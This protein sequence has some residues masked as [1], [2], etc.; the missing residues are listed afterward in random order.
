MGGIQCQFYH[1]VGLHTDYPLAL[2]CSKYY[3]WYLSKYYIDGWLASLLAG[4]CCNIPQHQPA[5]YSLQSICNISHRLN[6][7]YILATWSCLQPIIITPQPTV[8]SPHP[9]SINNLVFTTH[10]L[11]SPYLLPSH[12]SPLTSP[13]L[14]TQIIRAEEEKEKVEAELMRQARDLEMLQN[15]IQKSQRERENM[16]SEMEVLLDRINKMS[17]MLDKARVGCL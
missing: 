5:C 16:Q 10:F 8:H 17:D 7:L 4:L 12:L 2:L 6:M 13:L 14:Q 15:T 9:T 3:I 11:L 1:Y